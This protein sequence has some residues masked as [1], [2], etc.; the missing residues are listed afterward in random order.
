MN[1]PHWSQVVPQRETPRKHEE[2]R[3][4]ERESQDTV[5]VPSRPH[6][7]GFDRAAGEKTSP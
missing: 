3:A 6:F 1:Q 2:T 7:G 5:S 4:G